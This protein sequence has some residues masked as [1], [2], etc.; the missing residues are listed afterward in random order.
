MQPGDRLVCV[1]VTQLANG[2]VFSQWPL[3]ITLVPWFRSEVSSELLVE[4]FS[5]SLEDVQPFE[6]EVA[7]E[8]TF[9]YRGRK[10][11][12]LIKQPSPLEEIEGR[13]RHILKTNSSWIVDESTKAT[14]SF[15]PH[16]TFQK[17]ECLH[18]GDRFVCD[19]LYIIEQK[20]DH[21]LVAGTVGL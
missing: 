13:V 14:R 7:G 15:R 20:G 10:T 12:S 9:G 17:N 19:Q 3:H 1:L 16:V 21:K 4:L 11:V 18:E 2:A 8:A 5:E 6:V